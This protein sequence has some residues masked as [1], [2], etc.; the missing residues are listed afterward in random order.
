MT[1]KP[2]IERK[3][4]TPEVQN[5]TVRVSKETRRTLH[6]LSAMTGHSIASIIGMLAT[7]ELNRQQ[8]Q[9]KGDK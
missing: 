1:P 5:Y 4:P 2:L 6:Q 8:A 7:E 9:Q 3:P